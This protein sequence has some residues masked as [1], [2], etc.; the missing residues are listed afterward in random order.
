MP[1][2]KLEAG[3]RNTVLENPVE[4]EDEAADE[5]WLLSDEENLRVK[6]N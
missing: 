4:F 3:D 5:D 1:K 6:G 2:K